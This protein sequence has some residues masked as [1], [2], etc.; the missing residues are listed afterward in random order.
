M[1]SGRAPYP[2]PHTFFPKKLN[3]ITLKPCPAV[4]QSPGITM[5]RERPI[6]RVTLSDPVNFYCFFGKN[7]APRLL[8][9]VPVHFSKKT[10]WAKRVGREGGVFWGSGLNF[11]F[12]RKGRGAYGAGRKQRAG[13][14]P[15]PTPANRPPCAFAPR[16]TLLS[17][18]RPKCRYPHS[19]TN[20]DP[21]R[22]G[23]RIFRG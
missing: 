15:L 19:A 5:F 6:H 12:S 21:A 7:L 1:K 20:R 16:S 4:L 22:P 23:R 10:A 2:R 3:P 8:R 13:G 18:W 14:A 9:Y 17:P 11:C